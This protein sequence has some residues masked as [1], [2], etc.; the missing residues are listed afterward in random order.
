[1]KMDEKKL[2]VAVV[3]MG[4]M[5]LLHASIVNVLP[6]SELTAVYEKNSMSRRLMKRILPNTLFV[7][8]AE[9]L[10]DLGLDAVFVTT[11]IPSHFSIAQTLYQNRVACNIFVEKTLTKNYSESLE[12]CRLAKN[13]GGVSMVGYLRRFMVTFRKAKE[14]LDQNAIGEILS[15]SVN[16]LSSDFFGVKES[17]ASNSRGGVLR[18]LGSHAIDLALWFFGEV[19]VEKSRID[20]LTGLGAEDSVYC[21]VRA[22]SDSVKGELTISWCAEGYRMPEVNFVIKGSKGVI[23][24]N[25]DNVSLLTGEKST[26][27]FRHDLG[28]NVPFWLGAPEF[29]REDETFVKSISSDLSALIDFESASKVDKF[30][31]DIQQGA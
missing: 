27:W 11:P 26:S 1:M 20:S 16:A 18:D 17:E 24:V 21:A 3:G 31:E 2:K 23:T 15:F 12:L 14:L 4:K 7:D 29:Y 10:A 22:K 8:N 30:I 28:D 5:G 13:S 9:Q 25:D 6:E 19:R